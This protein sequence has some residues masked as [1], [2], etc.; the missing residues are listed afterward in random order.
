[1]VCRGAYDFKLQYEHH[2]LNCQV[3]HAPT[4]GQAFSG[5]SGRPAM[6]W[7]QCLPSWSMHSRQRDTLET[8]IHSIVITDRRQPPV[9]WN[10]YYVYYIPHSLLS[11]LHRLVVEIDGGRP[12]ERRQL[13]QSSLSK[14]AS[15]H[16]AETQIQAEEEEGFIDKTRG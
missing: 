6:S 2:P 4:L 11:I 14:T 12:N 16:S 1:M 10:I 8:I 13:A 3:P 5:R 15:H 7:R 9:L